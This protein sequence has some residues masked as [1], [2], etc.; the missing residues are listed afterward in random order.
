MRRRS[1]RLV[2]LAL[3]L[4]GLGAV[5]WFGRSPAE[6]RPAGMVHASEVRVGAEIGGRIARIA[7]A[8]GDRVRHGDPIATLDVP[9]L[10]ASLG[11]A[12]AAAAAAA[13]DR[14]RILSGVRPEQVGVAEEAVRTAEAR[15]TLAAEV[16]ARTA[17][18][19]T[20]GVASTATRDESAAA[21][22]NA[23]ADLALRQAELDAARAGPTAEERALADAD[24]ALAA[25]KV[26]ELEAR[27][28][29]AQVLAPV[30]GTV[31]IRVAEVGEI[32]AAGAPIVTLASDDGNWFGFTLREDEIGGLDVGAEVPLVA[33]A[34]PITARVVEMRPLGEF[35]TWRAARA[36]G[37]HD[38]A[39]LRIRLDP[40]KGA[41]VP[42]AGRTVWLP[43]EAAAT[44]SGG[45]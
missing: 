28:A 15:R 18:L 35:A 34:G 21:L 6:P 32:V 17:A 11:E 41:P 40:G 25:A 44:G 13:A 22:A 30:D 29:K 9:E 24:V 26:A 12:R 14:A 23:E 39:S 20:R 42:E 1:G 2:L 10:A 4:A 3:A 5:L 19:A 31:G 45:P 27:L 43:D 8:P 37:A 7:V 33:Q 36:V 38:L 16:D